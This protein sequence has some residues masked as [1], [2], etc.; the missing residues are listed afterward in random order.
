M[1]NPKAFF[2][3][4]IVG[5]VAMAAQCRFVVEREKELLEM[6][7]LRP[8]VVAR[9]DILKGTRLDETMFEIREIPF[10]WQQPQ[11]LEEVDMVL[12]QFAATPI[13]A[14]EQLVMNKLLRPIDAGLEFYVPVNARA[15]AIRVNEVQAVGGHVRPGNWVDVLG[16]FDFGRGE[17]SDFRTI[18]LFQHVWVLSVGQDVGPDSLR[19]V[20]AEDS[21]NPQGLEG[22]QS[23][24][25]ALS[26]EEVQKL[27]LA[28]HSG[29]LHLT[30]R[31]RNESGEEVPLQP[32]TIQSSIGIQERIR[33]SRRGPTIY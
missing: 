28:A 22:G 11:A 31:N 13:A 6:S 23:V 26:P 25:L 21:Y 19:P 17:S 14:G 10:K 29:D 32:A 1:K 2:I 5:V 20:T 4:L 27:V 8:T 15:V 30:L 3:A 16:T 24:S 9:V 33:A 18:T 7:E 12:G